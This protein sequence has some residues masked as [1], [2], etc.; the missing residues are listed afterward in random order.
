MRII[1]PSENEDPRKIQKELALK[2]C[3]QCPVCKSSNV[4][5]VGQD[6]CSCTVDA[7]VYTEHHMFW[8]KEYT[9][10]EYIC[11]SCKC[12]YES[13]PFDYCAEPKLVAGCIWAIIS[14]ILAYPFFLIEPTGYKLLFG[15]LVIASLVCAIL[16]FFSYRSH[17]YYE[18]FEPQ[19]ITISH[20]EESSAE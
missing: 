3:Y 19:E 5:A 18:G 17:D 8:N 16:C 13:D 7:N 10:I 6:S 11:A 20:S 1:K 15:A 14:A 9:R 12:H 2:E 4:Y